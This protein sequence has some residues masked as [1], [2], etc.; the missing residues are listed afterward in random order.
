MPGTCLEEIPDG[1]LR[2]EG[3]SFAITPGTEAGDRFSDCMTSDASTRAACSACRLIYP[4]ATFISLKPAAG[5]GRIEGSAGQANRPG[6][7][8]VAG[9]SK[10]VP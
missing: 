2:L 7:L 6:H 5:K 9:Q 4:T 1:Q 10:E 3:R 8:L